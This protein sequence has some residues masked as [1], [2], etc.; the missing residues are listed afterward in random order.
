VDYFKSELGDAVSIGQPSQKIKGIKEL[1]EKELLIYANVIGLALRIVS[2]DPIDSGINILPEEIK[3]T[4]KR[5]QQERRKWVWTS[6]ILLASLGILALLC[7][8]YYAY[9]YF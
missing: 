3:K 6:S 9:G 1:N 7:S 8:L 5:Y 4:E 2:D